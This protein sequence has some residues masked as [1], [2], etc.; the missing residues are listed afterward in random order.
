MKIA[1]ILLI[2]LALAGFFAQSTYLH[3]A[4]VYVGATTLYVLDEESGKI[5]GEIPIDRWIY[6]ISVS[7]DG[8]TVYA[9]ASNGVNIIDVETRTIQGLLM[10][11]PAFTVEIE[12]ESNRMFVLTNDRKV[13]PDGTAEAFPSKLLVYDLSSKTL[14]R[15]IEL[16]RMV[17]DI[18]IVPEQDRLYC[19]DLLD[20][21]LKIVQLTSGA[22]IETLDLGDYGYEHKDQ[23]QGMLWRMIRDKDSN[24]IYIAQGG[25]QAGVLVVET[26]TN[27]VRRIALDH[28]A[29][30]RGGVLSP[31]GKKL[32]LNAV[33]FLSVID[34][35]KEAEI[36]W[37]PL[38][39]PY[40]GMEIGDRGEK[41]YLINPVYD[42]GGS[43]AIFNAKTLAPLY[44]ILVP[45]ASPFTIAVGH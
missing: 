26:T 6:N 30:W 35:E 16:N 23:N 10:D 42:T 7:P 19:L 12:K 43:M 45:D 32:Y 8:K 27:S 15:T 20:S 25:N 5:A 36:S 33:R 29:K 21:E 18:E 37:V 2:A 17:F 1:S 31:D 22:Q 13:M 41:L 4:E 34:L 28:E 24:K 11:K 14:L 40:Q 38:D 44:R 9:G 39:V 3:G